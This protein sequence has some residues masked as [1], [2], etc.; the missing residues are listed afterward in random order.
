MPPR[1]IP[2]L[3]NEA[4]QNIENARRRNQAFSHVMLS[5]MITLC[6]D[7]QSISGNVDHLRAPE[8][9]QAIIALA[10]IANFDKLPPHPHEKISILSELS[11][12]LQT[13]AHDENIRPAMADNVLLLLKNL[14]LY[15]SEEIN[16]LMLRRYIETSNRLV[17]AA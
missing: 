13:A 15:A 7:V 16:P 11:T 6:K 2:A 14:I 8:A 10:A 1:S 5:Q 3:K 12:Y 17:G 4:C 9:T